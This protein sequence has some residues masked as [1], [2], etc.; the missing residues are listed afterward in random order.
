MKNIFQSFR[1]KALTAVLML[2]ASACTE[3]FDEL[4][5]NPNA[6]SVATADLFLPHG[7]QSAVDAYWGGSLGMDIGDLISQYWARI[8]YTDIDQ[9]SISSDVYSGAWQTFHVEALADYQRIYKLGVETKNP[10]Y[11][12]VALIMRSWVFSLLTDIYGD[13]PYMQSIQGLEGI[14]QPKYDTQKEVYAGIIKELKTANDMI[15]T[16]DKTKSISGDILFANDMTKWKKFANSLSLRLLN[17]MLSKADAAMDVKTEINRILSDPAKYPVI[18]TV[19]ETIQLNYLDA[20]NNNNPINQNR[21][22]RDDHRV[23]ATLVNKLAALKDARL[24]VYADRPADGGDYKGVPNGLSNADANALGLSKTSKVGAFFVGPTAPGV[25][26]SYAELLFIKAELAYKGITAAGD[27]A[28]NYAN[29]ITASHSQYK[30]TVSPEYLAANAFK[31]GTEGY[32]QIMEQKWIALYGQG[33]EAWTEFR[34]TGYP[35]LKPSVINVN[36]GVI[37]TRLPYP[38]S[39]ESLNFTNFSAALKQQGGAN[40]MKLKLWIAK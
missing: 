11:Q 22:T 9:Y 29:G 25:I 27:A 21:K 8:Q 34:R 18:G 15:E 12:A 14:L 33:I 20:T 7:I 26:L 39:E 16:A 6:P 32:K 1:Y 38:G 30:L 4:N 13:I 3:K 23:S 10:N 5:T 36:G 2:S 35:E 24:A 28:T 17:R 40:D 37:P 31:T 19:S